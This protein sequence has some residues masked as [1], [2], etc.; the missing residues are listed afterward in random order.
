[1]EGHDP[2]PPSAGEEVISD[3]RGVAQGQEQEEAVSRPLYYLQQVKEAE[4]TPKLPLRKG[5]SA[6][7]YRHY[8][9]NYVLISSWHLVK[10]IWIWL[11]TC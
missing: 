11:I 7:A 5:G 8:L 2:P 6:K 9:D 1:M 10:L 3:G 4:F